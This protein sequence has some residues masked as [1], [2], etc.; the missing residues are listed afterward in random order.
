MP[1]KTLSW[2][3]KEEA[4]QIAYTLGYDDPNSAVVDLYANKG[5]LT[6]K[7]A[8]AFNRTN[9][10]IYRRLKMLGVETRGRGGHYRDSGRECSLPAVWQIDNDAMI[11]VHDMQKAGVQVN[12]EHFKSLSYMFKEKMESLQQQIAE[13]SANKLINP[14][15]SDQ[16][17]D[18]LFYELNLTP[19]KRTKKGFS[20]DAKTLAFLKNAH[21][22]VEL[23][24]QWRQF[25][26]LH[27]TYTE[28]LPT[29]VKK[30]GRIYP[31]MRITA[32][33]TGRM[34]AANPNIMAIPTRTKE[35]KQIR[36][37]FVAKDGC[38]LASMDYSQIEMRVAAVASQDPVL[39]EVFQKGLD[40]HAQTAS[41]MFGIP[42]SRLDD[43][44]HRYPAKRVGFGILYGIQA[45]GLRAALIQGGA[46]E[47]EWSVKACEG[48]INSWFDVYKGVK[49]YMQGVEAF[50]RRNGYVQDIWGRRRYVEAVKWESSYIVAEA[51]RQACNAPIQMGAQGVMKLAMGK[52]VPWY[53]ASRKEGIEYS[54]LFQVHDDLIAE[55]DERHV[56]RI[57]KEQ[58]EIMEG[59]AGFPIETPVDPKIGFNWGEMEDFE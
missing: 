33:D 35:G 58:R 19:V 21:P 51:L 10:S 45:E 56:D 37:G 5:W 2:N 25:G 14:G 43:M 28:V 40:I 30:D 9:M 50:A 1:V 16:V 31:N 39:M 46:S 8:K 15:S 6:S 34:S 26:K 38:M 27:N 18:L 54:P 20:T 57:I 17:Q 52:M 11:M 49:K 7:I 48:L 44:K 29:L 13:Y 42:V 22:V 41:R 59:V 23:I 24:E 55:I 32:T 4:L 12:V 53:R 3:D 36:K 47:N